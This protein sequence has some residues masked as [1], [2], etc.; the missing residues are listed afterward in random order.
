MYMGIVVSYRI[1]KAKEIP[2]GLGPP[3][4]SEAKKEQSEVGGGGEQGVGLQSRGCLLGEVKGIS[5]WP[6][7][8]AD[9]DTKRT[10]VGVGR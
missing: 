6:E 3:F 2:A 7:L 10:G 5:K 9:K 1:A 4:K 8:E